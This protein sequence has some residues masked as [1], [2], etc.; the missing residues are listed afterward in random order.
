[1]TNIS[2]NTLFHFTRN[3]NNLKDILKEGF[4][5]N[6]CI[7]HWE[8]IWDF[9]TDV[10]IPMVC[11][12]DIPISQLRNHIN[13]YGKYAIGLTKEW[14]KLYEITP[15]LYTHN[16]SSILR[17]YNKII[18]NRRVSDDESISAYN[19]YRHV[20]QYIKPYE[21]KLPNNDEIIRFYNER[22]WRYVPELDEELH[23]NILPIPNNMNPLNDE[24]RALLEN[25]I[26][27]KFLI[28]EPND[29]RYIIVE[30][31]KEIADMVDYINDT[32]QDYSHKDV[33]LLTTRIISMEHIEGD[34]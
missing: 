25:N 3:I 5:P 16:N 22:E 2:A 34:F 18:G 10:E 28:F 32:F 1:M 9:S 15:V 6:F 20:L 4:K 12:C 23:K 11:F 27:N 26:K 29:I 19:S 31:D 33:K 8:N 17:H 7:E 30:K 13:T 21:G 14:A 24:Q